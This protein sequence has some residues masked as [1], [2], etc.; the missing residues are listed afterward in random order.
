MASD[1]RSAGRPVV[2]RPVTIV[3]GLAVGVLG[4]SAGGPAAVRPSPSA[5]ASTGP[6]VVASVEL[7][8]PEREGP[9]VVVEGR[10]WWNSP[11]PGCAVLRLDGGQVLRLT[12][13]AVE[14]RLAEAGEG[15]A[16]VPQRTRIT[17]HVARSGASVCGPHPAFVVQKVDVTAAG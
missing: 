13:S 9:V 4:C 7:P 15:R 3:L 1:D 17:G 5:T 14:L 2:I 12:G 16:D 10:T 6:P 8:P 11:R